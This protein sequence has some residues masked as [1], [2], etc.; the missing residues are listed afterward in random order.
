[1]H[2]IEQ[3]DKTDADI[4]FVLA[5]E[6]RA[7]GDLLAIKCN[8]KGAITSFGD[9]CGKVPGRCCASTETEDIK[10][11]VGDFIIRILLVYIPN[12]S[13][14]RNEYRLHTLCHAS[15]ATP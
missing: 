8:P 13:T 4:F 11:D 3:A 15:L 9:F 14:Y 5:N 7:E 2:G 6:F 10:H 12:M 1:C